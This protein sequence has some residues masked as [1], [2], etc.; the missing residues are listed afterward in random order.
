MW[1]F[2]QQTGDVGCNGRVLGKA[3]SGHGEGKNNPAMEQLRETGPIPRGLYT[4][5]VPRKY[6]ELG[7][8]AM[9]LTPAEGTDTFGRAG[10]YWHGDSA[11]HPGEASHGC[12][13]S[14]HGLRLEAW[15]S[16]DH[17]LQV[18]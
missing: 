14:D 16:G 3:Y 12:I 5:G 11:E 6:P 8:D 10:F 7:A 4:I 9:P 13:V 18:I 2:N 17:E 1:T 15:Y